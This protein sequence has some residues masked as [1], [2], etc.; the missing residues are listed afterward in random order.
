MVLRQFQSAAAISFLN[1]RKRGFTLVELLVVIGIIA[2]LISILLPALGKAREQAKITKCLSN[3]RSLA[4]GVQM[5][6]NE[7]KGFICAVNWGDSPTVNGKVSA[8]WLYRAGTGLYPF[9]ANLTEAQVEEGALWPYVKVH[10]VYRCPGHDLENIFGR[11]DSQ[12]SYL[13]NGAMNSF[14]GPTPAPPNPGPR[15]YPLSK[16]KAD[17][18][19]FWEADE[20]PGGASPFNDG[21]SYPHES[22]NPA[23]TASAGYGSRHGKFSTIA[24]VDAHA[25]IIPHQEIVMLAQASVRNI[26]WCAPPEDRPTGH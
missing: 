14:D 2:L 16:F 22:F 24:F 9:A 10:E 21:S 11:T 1:R 7:N 20:R 17:S 3:L 26:L 5:Y 12:V 13:M 6:A 4:Y 19:V 18:V 23:A 8:G 15:V 25:E